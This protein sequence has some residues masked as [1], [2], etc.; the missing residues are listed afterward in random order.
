MLCSRSLPNLAVLTADAS[1]LRH[2]LVLALC[3]CVFAFVSMQHAAQ[4]AQTIS[5]SVLDA[6]CDD[7]I[8]LPITPMTH[9]F[10]AA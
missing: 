9:L 2:G 6:D 5:V 8:M 10:P 1:A 4:Y 3:S 7:N